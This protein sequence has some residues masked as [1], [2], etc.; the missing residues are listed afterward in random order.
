MVLISIKYLAD[1]PELVPL[2]STW[3]FNEW[4]RNNPAL[5]VEVIEGRVR[6]RLNRDKPPLCLVAFVENQPVAT[7]ALKI[8]EMET[9]TQYA[10]WL[11]NVYVLP[12][13]RAQGIGT[14]VIE[15]AKYEAKRIGIRDLYLYTRDRAHLYARL[16]WETIE[17][18]PYRGRRATIMWQEL[19]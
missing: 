11:G 19:I 5:T 4:G 12:E 7:A 18:A 3:F 16:G 10:H 13:F 6:E 2:L 1:Q 9:H 8:R 15:R 14:A 17:Q